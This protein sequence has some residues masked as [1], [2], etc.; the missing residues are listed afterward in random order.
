M[1][2]LPTEPGCYEVDGDRVSISLSRTPVLGQ[3]GGAMRIEDER[4]PDRIIIVHG[5]DGEFQ[6][7]RNRCACGGFRIDPVPGE[8]RMRCVTPMQST[9]EQDGKPLAKHVEKYLDLL[10]VDVA[11]GQLTIDCSSIRDT[12]PPHERK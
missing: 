2:P 7:Y 3:P 11:E 9:Y 8:E 6:C 4:L 10:P 5:Q 12:E 1:A